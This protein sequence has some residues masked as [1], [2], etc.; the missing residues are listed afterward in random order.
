MH[1]MFSLS[2][3][4]LNQDNFK[5]APIFTLRNLIILQLT[6]RSTIYL[7]CFLHIMWIRYR[8]FIYI[9]YIYFQ[10]PLYQ[11]SKG[12]YISSEMKCHLC[13][14]F[15]SIY[16]CLF[17]TLMFHLCIF[18][19][20]IKSYCINCYSFMSWNTELRLLALVFSLKIAWLTLFQ[21]WLSSL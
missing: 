14:K 16:V 4:C 15:N 18:S 2:S 21:P 11:F 1:F 8:D 5:Y 3:L 20:C 13:G 9:I 12:L 6:F 10:F 17:W 19:A 7:R